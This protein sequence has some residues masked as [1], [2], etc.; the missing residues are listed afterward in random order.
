MFSFIFG[1]GDSFGVESDKERDLDDDLDGDLDGD[2]EGARTT[3]TRDEFPLLLLLLLLGAIGTASGGINLS[4]SDFGANL[5][6]SMA[7]IAERAWPASNKGVSYS[8]LF[9][10][11]SGQSM[12]LKTVEDDHRNSFDDKT[13][14]VVVVF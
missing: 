3:K 10:R 13:V 9:E 8:M 5:S 2:L 14:T 1:D 4:A 12:H 6:L 7:S 11:L